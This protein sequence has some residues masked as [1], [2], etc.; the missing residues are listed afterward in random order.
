MIIDAETLAYMN[1]GLFI[2]Q[3][4]T[5]VALMVIYMIIRSKMARLTRR[6]RRSVGSPIPMTAPTAW[7]CRD[8]E[9]GPPTYASLVPGSPRPRPVSVHGTAVPRG[10]NVYQAVP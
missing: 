9:E 3:L 1:A 5:V 6:N 10:A 7:A 4:V 2:G 8:L